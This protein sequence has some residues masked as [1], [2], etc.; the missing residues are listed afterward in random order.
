MGFLKG[1]FLIIHMV[2]I[3]G[4]LVVCLMNF[5]LKRPYSKGLLH[6]ALTMLVTG[7]VM[8]GLKEGLDEPVNHLKIGLKLAVVVAITALVWVNRNREQLARGFYPAVMALT[9]LNIGLAYG[10]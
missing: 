4:I 8:V 6:M 7:I 2:T 1:L 10:L 9:V 3:A 5:V